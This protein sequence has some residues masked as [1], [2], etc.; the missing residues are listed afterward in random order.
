MARGIIISLM[1]AI[2]L[3]ILFKAFGQNAGAEDADAI[4]RIL[5]NQ[6]IIIE[7]LDAIDGKVD[8]LKTR[9]R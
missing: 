8:I 1:A 5:A 3:L 2:I 9:I 7:K 6:R 4:G